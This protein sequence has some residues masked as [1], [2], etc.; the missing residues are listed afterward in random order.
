MSGVV[1]KHVRWDRTASKLVIFI[2]DGT[3]GISAEAANASDQSL[4]TVE[5]LAFVRNR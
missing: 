4:V 5:V 2:E 1:T 3:S